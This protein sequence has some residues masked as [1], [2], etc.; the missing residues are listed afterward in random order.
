M[1]E[2]TITM[3]FT[4]ESEKSDY[5]SISEFA[6]L[7]SENIMNDETLTS[8]RDIE[9]TDISIHEIEDYNDDEE[10]MYLEDDE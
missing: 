9:I 8:Y 4:V 6:E 1:K 7:L 2:Y 10:N 5:E 3:N